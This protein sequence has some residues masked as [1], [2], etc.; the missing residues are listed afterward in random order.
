MLDESDRWRLPEGGRVAVLGA[1][2]MGHAIAAI[3]VNAGYDV[4]CVDPDAPTRESLATRV[5]A[6]IAQLPTA[7]K[8][9]TTISAVSESRRCWS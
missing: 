7:A 9:T 6:V 5:D 4:T 2:L 3:F 1:G 8:T